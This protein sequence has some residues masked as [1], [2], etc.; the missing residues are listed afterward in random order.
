MIFLRFLYLPL[1]SFGEQD[2]TPIAFGG[3][4]IVVLAQSLNSNDA[5]TLQFLSISSVALGEDSSTFA[6]S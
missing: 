6:G 1:V 5:N 3:I 2:L 4:V